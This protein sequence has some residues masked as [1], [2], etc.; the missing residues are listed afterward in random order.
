M[1]KFEK[2]SKQA[3][4][5]KKEKEQDDDEDDNILPNDG[6]VSLS[7]SNLVAHIIVIDSL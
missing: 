6:F 2:Y 7:N 5:L 4:K 3:E 1:Q